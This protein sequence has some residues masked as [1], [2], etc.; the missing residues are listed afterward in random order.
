[1]NRRSILMMAV[2]VG[3]G[4]SVACAAPA[5]VATPAPTVPAVMKAAARLSDADQAVLK[6]FIDSQ[7]AKLSSAKAAEQEDARDALIKEV[8]GSSTPAYQ[9]AYAMTLATAAAKLPDSPDYRTRLN[10]AVAVGRVAERSQNL[11]LKALALRFAH[12]K[13]SAVALW[14]V[15]AVRAMLPL[16][17]RSQIQADDPFLTRLVPAISDNLSGPVVQVAYEAYRL[18]ILVDRRS[19]SD[20]ML[21][22]VIPP[23]QELFGTRLALYAA[24]GPDEPQVDTLASNFLV[25]GAVWNVETT[26][27]KTQTLQSIAQMVY[28]ASHRLAGLDMKE[29]GARIR[30]E[31]LVQTLR[32]AGGG[33]A[34]VAD[35]IKDANLA[36]A[37]SYIAK[38]DATMDGEGIAKLC[39]E[40]VRALVETP[41]FKGKLKMPA[42][43]PTAAK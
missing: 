29:P 35:T 1:M 40:A 18:N 37:A 26:Q 38:L 7:V 32:I 11:R 22:A 36:N 42:T 8:D 25:N 41:Q 19:L 6:T 30:R 23:M 15:K 43:A 9:D 10:A 17:L 12:D 14:G 31:E 21:R 13:S 2:N 34:V 4:L 39:D 28:G 3:L 16:Q 5:P 27:Q 20:D 24:D 33:M